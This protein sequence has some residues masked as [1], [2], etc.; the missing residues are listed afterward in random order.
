[1]QKRVALINTIRGYA[2][3]EGHRLPERFFSRADWRERLSKT[4]FS[5]TLH[6]VIASFMKSID[7]LRESEDE[8]TKRIAEIK[9]E[10]L[11]RLESVPSFGMLTSRTILGALDDAKRFDGKKAASK[12]GALAPTIYQSGGVTQLGHVNRNGR[13]EVRRVLLQCAHTITRMKSAG[14]APLRVFYERIARKRGKKIAI[15][16]LARKLLTIAYGILKHG[17]YY[18]PAKLLPAR[19]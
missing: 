10:R 18:D 17:T 16:A 5:A 1:M 2:R 12:Y 15:V 14:A 8:L 19:A 3:Q 4:K 11:K 9:D 7:G 13:H 6:A